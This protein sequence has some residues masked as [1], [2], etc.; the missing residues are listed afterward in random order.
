MKFAVNNFIYGEEP[1]EE[2]LKRLAKYGYD[3]VEIVSFEPETMN[4]N[5][6][7][8]LLKSYELEPRSVC[9]VWPP[10]KDLISGD[11]KSREAAIQYAKVC[12][13]LIAD[14]EGDLFTGMVP[15]AVLKIKPMASEEEEWRWGVEGIRNVAKYAADF[16]VRIAIEP[17]NRFETYFINRSDQALRLMQDINMDNVGIMLDNFHMNIEESSPLEAI[18]IAGKHLWGFHVADSNRMPPGQGHTDWK[19]IINALKGIGYD[20]YLVMEFLAPMDRTPIKTISYEDKHSGK[21]LVEYLIA[22]GT[23]T[24]SRKYYDQATEYS[25]NYMKKLL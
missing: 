5:E 21:P 23:R 6:I 7:K 10:E 20:D 13:K 12:C 16:G 22:H 9:G 19:A 15:S 25:I 14:L 2:T 4:A 17:L 1:F 18:K 3:G 24:L 11:R 8:G